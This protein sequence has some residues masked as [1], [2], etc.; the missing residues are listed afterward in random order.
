MQLLIYAI[1]LAACIAVLGYLA[2]AS[3]ESEDIW[4]IGIYSGKDPLSLAPHSLIDDHPVLSAQDVTDTD[5]LFVAD[6][7]LVALSRQW[8]MFFEVFD[9]ATR[10]GQIAYATSSDGLRWK[11]ERLVLKEPFHLSYPQVFYDEGCY[12]MIPESAEAGSLRL[13]RADNFPT[14]WS[15]VSELLPGQFLDATILRRDDGWYLFA[16]RDNKGLTLYC[17]DRLT[18]PWIE[19]QHSP[20]ATDGSITRPGGRLLQYGGKLLRFSQDGTRTYGHRVFASEITTLTR[21]DYHESL[22]MAHSTIRA[23]GHGWNADGMHHI[24]LQAIDQGWIAAVDGKY[25]RSR[26]NWRKGVRAMINHIVLRGT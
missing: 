23:S 16:L 10:R 3:F 2:F 6:P 15:L 4:S 5:A 8:L 25:V 17:A 12:Y 19:H 7:F 13:Y 22:P 1:L 18:G 9:V 21:D 14:Q 24:D 20:V 11:Y 26:L